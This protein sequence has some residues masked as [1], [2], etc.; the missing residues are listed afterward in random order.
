MQP[1]ISV[2][3]LGVEDL[4]RAL[5]FYRDGLGL[6][7][8]G[9]VGTEFEGGAVAFFRLQGGL[10]L[11]LWPRESLARETG[12][13]AGEPTFRAA[14]FSIGHNVESRDEA[15]RVMAQAAAA[16]ARIIDPGQDRGWGGYSGYFQGLDGHLWE[17]VWNPNLAGIA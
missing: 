10:I 17:V 3:T 9:I 6:P 13:E 15:D 4:E 5:V 8:Q 7:T 1:S 12:L 14:D 2:I 16:G 11:A